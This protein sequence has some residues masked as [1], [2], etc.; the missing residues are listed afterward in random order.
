[1][2][3][4]L[5]KSSYGFDLTMFSKLF[6]GDRSQSPSMTMALVML[7]L[8]APF[9]AR[10]SAALT[11]LPHFSAVSSDLLKFPGVPTSE[12]DLVSAYFPLVSVSKQFLS[13][14]PVTISVF[15]TILIDI[16]APQRVRSFGHA[17]DTQCQCHSAPMR[18]R[19]RQIGQIV[20]SRAGHRW[21]WRCFNIFF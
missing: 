7:H 8:S 2:S 21:R 20:R 4:V 13:I 3:D 17:T 18:Q 12:V 14:A 11:T 1:M 10:L 9:T 16:T 19:L 15:A 5:Y 6:A